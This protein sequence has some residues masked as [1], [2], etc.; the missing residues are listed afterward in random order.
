MPDG[1][2]DVVEPVAPRHVVVDVVRGD[3]AYAK[4]TGETQETPVPGR[5][6]VDQVALQL[7]EYAIRPE[8]LQVRTQLRLG[9]VYPARGDQTGDRTFRAAG[10]QDQPLGVVRQ[11]QRVQSGVEPASLLSHPGV[12]DQV[13]EVRVAPARLGQ[14]GQMRAVGEGHLGA[15]YWLEVHAVGDPGELHCPAE[16]VVVRKGKGRVAQL[17]CAY[18]EILQRGRAL[19]ERVAAVAV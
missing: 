11:E 14:K 7:Y 3:D 12:G 17:L 9:V 8:P 4:R 19:F 18:G 13:A 15:G 5:V 16:V 10:Q 1:D 6:T 2:Q